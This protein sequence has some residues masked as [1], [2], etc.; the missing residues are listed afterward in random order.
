MLSQAI[1]SFMPRTSGPQAVFCAVRAASALV[2]PDAVAQFS[3]PL[4]DTQTSQT[5]RCA[6]SVDTTRKPPN[7]RVSPTP[8]SVER[9]GTTTSAGATAATTPASR[10]WLG[11]YAWGVLGYNIAVVLWGAFVRATGSGAGCGSHWPLCNGEVVP[12]AP[13]LETL[14]EMTHRVTS[15]GAGLLVFALAFWVFRTRP[16]GDGARRAVVA[17]VVFMLLEGALGAGLVLLELTADDASGRR[18][19]ALGLHLVNT[20]LLLA[21]IAL[22]AWRL[23]GHRAPRWTGAG[24]SSVLVFGLLGLTMLTGASGAVTALGDTLF[25]A[26]SLREGLAADFSPTAHLLVRLRVWHPALAILTA[27]ATIAGARWL[28][29]RH[30]APIVQRLAG[31]VILV[32]AAQVLGGF[33]NLALLAPTAMQLVHLLL[34]DAAWVL[35]VLLGSSALATASSPRRA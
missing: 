20:F 24:P 32:W 9:L 7:P 17:S 18:A 21:A 12:R 3:A 16:S 26:G 5:S 31:W 6:R 2:S 33:I 34:A 11:R 8:M 22:T 35:L 14:I 4:N 23:G 13:S 19:V 28:A 30:P 29:A 27:L 1:A 15:A 10:P 25:P